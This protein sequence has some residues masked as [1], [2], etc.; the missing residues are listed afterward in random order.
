[1]LLRRISHLVVPSARESSSQLNFGSAMT[2]KIGK[3]G[4]DWLMYLLAFAAALHQLILS[5][6]REEVT[7]VLENILT[8]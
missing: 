5:R 3:V 2:P 1:M 6:H 7:V 4:P 8:R